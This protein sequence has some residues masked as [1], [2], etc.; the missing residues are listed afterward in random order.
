MQ[1]LGVSI[2]KIR[3]TRSFLIIWIIRYYHKLLLEEI[4]LEN[5]GMCFRKYC[6][7]IFSFIL[8]SSEKS[9]KSANQ[10]VLIF[11]SVYLHLKL[12]SVFFFSFFFLFIFFFFL[13]PANLQ[14]ICICLNPSSLWNCKYVTCLFLFAPKL[15]PIWLYFSNAI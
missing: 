9:W 13:Q 4:C 14:P 12:W 10:N 8:V 15:L 1:C 7:K 11:M 5:D 2:F 3:K 6:K